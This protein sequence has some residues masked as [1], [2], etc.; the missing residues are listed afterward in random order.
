M[1]DKYSADKQSASSQCVKQ[2]SS[3]DD[4][5]G[6]LEY[7]LD[8]LTDCTFAYRNA[9]ERLLPAPQQDTKG[10]PSGGEPLT[11]G[12]LNRFSVLLSRLERLNDTN[13]GII[14]AFDS[15]I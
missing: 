13:Q 3:M 8:R 15:F 10:S 9:S 14:S 7:Q 5:L 11:S 2:M 6:T 12:H 1:A 4:L